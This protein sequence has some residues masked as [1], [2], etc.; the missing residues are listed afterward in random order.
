MNLFKI[1]RVTFFVTIFL[2]SSLTKDRATAQT[3]NYPNLKQIAIQSGIDANKAFSPSITK[4]AP[5][6]LNPT[7]TPPCSQDNPNATL[8]AAYTYFSGS[9]R[10]V[11]VSR[12]L[13][14]GANWSALKQYDNLQGEIT[15]TMPTWNGS[16]SDF[17]DNMD[18]AQITTLEQ[19]FGDGYAFD[20][21]SKS[22]PIDPF[23][24][25]SVPGVAIRIIEKERSLMR[26][27]TADIFSVKQ[28]FM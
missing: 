27:K 4:A 6:C 21:P 25:L 13:D 15:L 8:V 9:S 11:G 17:L 28:E 2:C 23:F 1:R 12:S 14:G 5:V 24:W 16:A 22:H 19:P 20:S 7:D 18:D 26:P 10:K 3:T